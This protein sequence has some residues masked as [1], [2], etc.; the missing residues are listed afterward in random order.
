MLASEVAASLEALIEQEGDGT[1]FQGDG[2]EIE[3]VYMSDDG[4]TI[5]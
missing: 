2:S 3:E 4:I 1:A 5:E